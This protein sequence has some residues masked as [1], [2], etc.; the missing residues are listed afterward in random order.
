[1]FPSPVFIPLDISYNLQSV[2]QILGGTMEPG[3]HY[4]CDAESGV[5]STDEEEKLLAKLEID[6]GA[7]KGT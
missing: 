2:G 5:N 3:Y 6:T 7:G 1:M 4:P